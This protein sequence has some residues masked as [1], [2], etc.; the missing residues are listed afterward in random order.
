M[1]TQLSTNP[2]SPDF[3]STVLDNLRPGSALQTQIS[4]TLNAALKCQLAA[5]AT[6]ADLPVLL[7]LMN[8]MLAA[9]RATSEDLLLEE[10]AQ[11]LFDPMASS[12]PAM[13]AAIDNEIAT[14]PGTATVSTTLNLTSPLA[15]HPL[16]H[17]LVS[18]AR[19]TSQLAASPAI[20]SEPA[21]SFVTLS[22]ANTSSTLDLWT[23]LA[24]DLRLKTVVP[25]LQ[26]TVQ[27]GTLT[28]NDTDLVA[29]LM[30]QFNPT[31]VSDLTK[32]NADTRRVFQVKKDGDT[33]QN[34]INLELCI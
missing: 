30:A 11:R 31:A 12:D 13:K 20:T 19:L 29:K 18:D 9:D 26:L 10:F 22:D 3:T 21:G 23:Q 24:S 4:E 28:S 15:T 2:S 34:Q 25:E 7:A 16:L 5:A 33:I 17:S 27:L 1:P 8:A 14:L 32:L 6:K